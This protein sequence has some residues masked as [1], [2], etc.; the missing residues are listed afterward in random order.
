M[1]WRNEK[2]VKSPLAIHFLRF[3]A[4]MGSE[5]GVI[6]NAKRVGDCRP[7]FA[8]AVYPPAPWAR[9]DRPSFPG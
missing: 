6:M 4:S 3:L 7:A 1:S 2:S 9:T 8:I 5:K